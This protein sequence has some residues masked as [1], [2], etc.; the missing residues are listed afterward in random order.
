M[1]KDVV[2]NGGVRNFLAKVLEGLEASGDGLDIEVHWA[3]AIIMLKSFTSS[4]TMAHS[5]LVVDRLES[6]PSLCS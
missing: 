4:D 5:Q 6:L 2:T 1:A 3:R